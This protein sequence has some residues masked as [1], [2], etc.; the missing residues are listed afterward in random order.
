[1]YSIRLGVSHLSSKLIK[2]LAADVYIV[3]IY[4]KNYT[5]YIQA[6]TLAAKD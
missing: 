3:L 6:F 2:S 1:M 5:R 4:N